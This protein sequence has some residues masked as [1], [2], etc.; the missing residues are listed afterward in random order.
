M[1]G[2]PTERI[3]KV[4]YSRHCDGI[5]TIIKEYGRN[6]GSLTFEAFARD[7]RAEDLC[8][9]TRTAQRYWD[10]LEAKGVIAIRDG[11]HYGNAT[12]YFS[13]LISAIDDP[14]VREA[15]RRNSSRR[16]D[17]DDA[18]SHSLSQ[19]AEAVE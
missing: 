12:L 11:P 6:E 4:I 13:R 14:E 5:D 1:R 3:I 7:M 18:L 16:G 8:V 9:D 17:A 15:M 2:I 10:V 19:N